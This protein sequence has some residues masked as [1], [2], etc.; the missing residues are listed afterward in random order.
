MH[1]WLWRRLR[2]CCTGVAGV[3]GGARSGR[4]LLPII[5]SGHRAMPPLSP[6]ESPRRVPGRHLLRRMQLWD[7]RVPPE[8][9]SR[10]YGWS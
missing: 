4:R 1:P 7:E 6:C 9:R 5:V 2:W 3:A 10:L 8:F